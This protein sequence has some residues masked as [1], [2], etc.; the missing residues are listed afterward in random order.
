MTER[1]G[2]SHLKPAFIST[3]RCE[4]WGRKCQCDLCGSCRAW[5]VSVQRDDSRDGRKR[6]STD[7]RD[8][9]GNVHAIWHVDHDPQL[10]SSQYFDA[11]LGKGGAACNTLLVPWMYVRNTR[12]ALYHLLSACILSL[13]AVRSAK[14]SIKQDGACSNPTK[15]SCFRRRPAQGIGIMCRLSTVAGLMSAARSMSESLVS[16]EYRNP[17]RLPKIPRCT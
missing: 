8:L 16:C 10:K 14:L 15:P 9:R 13:H 2:H 17:R 1:P 11:M 7:H 4:N 6:G 3:T 5:R 12:E